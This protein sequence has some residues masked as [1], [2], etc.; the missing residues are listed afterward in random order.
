MWLNFIPKFT[1][2]E[3]GDEVV[4]LFKIYLVNRTDAG[5]KFTYKQQFFGKAIL[6]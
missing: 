2:D 4:E 3:F 5:Y 6:N 1:V